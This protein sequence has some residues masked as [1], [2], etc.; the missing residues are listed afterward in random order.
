MAKKEIRG[1]N[2][3]AS[4]E[5]ERKGDMVGAP[6]VERFDELNHNPDDPTPFLEHM[7]ELLKTPFYSLNYGIPQFRQEK[8]SHDPK[9]WV[10]KWFFPNA[11]GGPVYVD[12]P[13]NK[14]DM[15]VCLKKAEIMK[16]LKFS[17]KFFRPQEEQKLADANAIID[18]DA[19]IPANEVF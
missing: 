17:Y 13:H 8:V 9:H 12:Y 15:E 6:K 2:S 4:V 16:R 1:G 18:P 19:E 3:V 10:V 11:K 5:I 7:G 14:A